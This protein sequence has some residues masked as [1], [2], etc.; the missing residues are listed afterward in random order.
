[1]TRILTDKRAEVARARAQVGLADLEARIRAAAP[2]RGFAAAL[3]ASVARGKPAVVAEM[4]RA[5]PS[6]GVL[7]QGLDPEAVARAYERAGAS[8]LSVL[9]DAHYFGAQPDDL[10]RARAACRL[11]V[12]RK[13][14]MVDAYQ[15]AQSRAMDADCVLLIVAALPPGELEELYDASQAYGLDALI[16]VHDAAEL[17][18]ALALPG[19]LL[20]INNRDLQ[21][22]V[23]TIDRTLELVGF[24]PPGRLVVTESGILGQ[25]EVQRLKA[26]GLRGFLVGEAFMVA[27]DPGARLAELFEGWV[28][29]SSS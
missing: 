14:F 11:P 3:S 13:D 21:S 6:R 25:D 10:V 2:A 23:T 9:T 26:A 16:E 1:M 27:A 24:V 29:E 15:I 17:E 5:S 19:G 4:K 28:D 20:G 12:L 7:R 18:R 8:A 22:F